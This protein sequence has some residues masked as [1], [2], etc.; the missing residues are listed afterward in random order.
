M[1]VVQ[2]CHKNF[3]VLSLL[4]LKEWWHSVTARFLSPQC[5]VI[6]GQIL[7]EMCEWMHWQDWAIRRF[8]FHNAGSHLR[9]LANAATTSFPTLHSLHGS[10]KRPVHVGQ[11]SDWSAGSSVLVSETDGNCGA[12]YPKCYCLHWWFACTFC[13]A[14]G[15]HQTAW[16]TTC[17]TCDAQCQNKSAQM[18]FWKSKHCTPRFLTDQERSQTGE[19]QAESHFQSHST[20]TKFAN[21]NH[22]Q[23]QNNRNHR[24]FHCQVISVSW[25]LQ[26]L[27]YTC[28]E[29]WATHRTS[30]DVDKKT[31][32]MERKGSAAIG[33]DGL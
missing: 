22:K 31:L 16:Q 11:I 3:T 30:H 4:W 1:G 33:L 6:C 13:K 25:A 15:P 17:S 2:P 27:L 21:K 32:K 10:G 9:F 24:T 7:N 19:W 8:N 18:F 14:S 29:F 5:T 26:F 20:R 23:Y 12:R 28:A